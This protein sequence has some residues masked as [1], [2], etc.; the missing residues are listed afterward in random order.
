MKLKTQKM[1]TT[2]ARGMFT[3]LPSLLQDDEVLAVTNWNTPT[4]A[5]L[6][7]ETFE[8]LL[9]S[10]EMLNDPKIVKVLKNK[11]ETDPLSQVV[12]EFL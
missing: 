6:K 7:W 4:L 11:L 9:F 3:R 10:L 12:K 2:D 5:V 8:Q 1:G